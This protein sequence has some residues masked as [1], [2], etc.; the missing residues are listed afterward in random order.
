MNTYSKYCPNVFLAKC[1]EKHDKGETID[2][3][4]KYGSGHEAIVFN[5]VYEKE[6]FYFYSVV[7]A[8]GFNTQEWANRRAERLQN[9]SR[10][11]ES[12]SNQYYTA[13]NKDAGF[14]SLG[15]PIKVGHHSEHRH[16]KIIDQAWN[17]MGKSVEFSNLAAEYDSRAEYW[18]HKAKT[19][20]LSMPECVEY[21]EYKLELAR[22][23]HEAYK[24][25]TKERRH[26][27]SLTYAKKA[28]NDLE[29]N[30]KIANRLWS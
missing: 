23:E 17:N 29:A 4:T 19:M 27:F 15:E 18:E 20:N 26:S 13:S 5:L 1:T 6:G 30:L 24:N 28:V 12:K 14:L 7:R 16:R 10:K 22:A 9:A 25:G 3:T 11:A 8:D 2:M 21:Y